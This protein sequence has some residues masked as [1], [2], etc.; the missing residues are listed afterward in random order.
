MFQAPSIVYR[1][2]IDDPVLDAFWIED[3]VLQLGG[4]YH[5]VAIRD[6]ML[7]ARLVVDRAVD[8]GFLSE[9]RPLVVVGAGAAGATAAFRAAEQGIDTVLIE[10]LKPFHLQANCRSRWIDPT[11][12]DWPAG[13]F[14]ASSCPPWEP[15]ELPFRWRAD[16]ACRLAEA[17]NNKLS[18][19]HPHLMFYRGRT[20]AMPLSNGETA[21]HGRA[22]THRGDE[23]LEVGVELNEQGR[24]ERRI[25]ECGLLILC[26][27]PG[28]EIV[29]AEKGDEAYR[30][31]Q[32]WETDC[33]ESWQ[34]GLDVPARVLISG[35]GDGALQDFLRLTTGVRSARRLFDALFRGWSGLAA[36]E[37]EVRRL[38]DL[39]GRALL[40]ASSPAD[41]HAILRE[42][43]EGYTQIVASLDSTVMERA[44]RL[45]SGRFARRGIDRIQMV[46]TC[47][48][49][50]VT[51][52]LNHLLALVIARC[53][54]ESGRPSPFL[55]GH[56][57]IRV[58]DAEGKSCGGARGCHG[59]DHEVLLA[60][61]P[62][63]TDAAPTDGA[64]PQVFNVV[65]L[66]HGVEKP[67]SE[68]VGRIVGRRQILPYHLP[69]D[70]LT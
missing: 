27:G 54:E 70:D 24:A 23:V 22:R 25:L 13:H 1:S 41:D 5:P 49:F 6:Q 42:L 18:E 68:R 50:G 66:R 12:Y 55:P 9:D 38:E 46:F 45:I 35:A 62:R 20:V 16:R 37:S 39:A 52:P 47:S 14:R 58:S 2:T 40:W 53:L 19:L 64:I 29:R 59:R 33:F 36:L 4:R 3:L 31:F 8:L 51:Y 57:V 67:P 44:K 11:Q 61:Q 34:V 65:V 21:F 17:W 60:P 32:F 56:R 26:V 7:R 30:G 63:C 69:S 15:P 48:H 28:G 43:H 10:V